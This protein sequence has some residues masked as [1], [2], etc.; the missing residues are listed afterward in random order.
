[1][2]LTAWMP[3]T[4][5]VGGLI[6]A[7]IIALRVAPMLAQKGRSD[8][9]LKHLGTL[10][11]TPQCSVALVRVGRETL[12]LGVTSQSVS[13][14]ARTPPETPLIEGAPADTATPLP[15]RVETAAS[16]TESEAT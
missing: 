14:L 16:I 4:L 5:L 3:F 1:M 2:A 10:A 8:R 9:L 11:L 12:V 15:A 7:G 6:V 13:L